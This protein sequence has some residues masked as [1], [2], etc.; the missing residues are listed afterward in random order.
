MICVIVLRE[1]QLEIIVKAVVKTGDICANL[2]RELEAWP[3]LSLLHSSGAAKGV[4]CFP[5]SKW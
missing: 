3:G 4:I 5:D 1:R 2:C